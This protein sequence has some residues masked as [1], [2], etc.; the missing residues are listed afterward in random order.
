MPH[1]ARIVDALNGAYDARDDTRLRRRAVAFT[2]AYDADTVTK[3]YW[4]PV[5]DLLAAGEEVAA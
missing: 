1:V 5:L 2:G 3:T 4:A